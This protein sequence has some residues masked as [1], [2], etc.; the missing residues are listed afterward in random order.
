MLKHP[1]NCLSH[2]DHEPNELKFGIQRMGHMPGTSQ[3]W[4]TWW[5]CGTTALPQRNPHAKI[6][7]VEKEEEIRGKCA[8]N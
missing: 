3:A 8:S 4:P 7:H 1:A 2:S 5:L 6:A